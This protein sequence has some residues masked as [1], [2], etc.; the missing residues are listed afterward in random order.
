[1]ERRRAKKVFV[2]GALDLSFYLLAKNKRGL[3]FPGA[4][5]LRQL[6]SLLNKLQC[7]AEQENY[8]RGGSEGAE[9]QNPYAEGILI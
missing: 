8:S 3:V 6:L 4:K 9:K 5:R 2:E 1:M 7:G